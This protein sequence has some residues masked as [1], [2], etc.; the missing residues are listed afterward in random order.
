MSQSSG[1][2]TAPTGTYLITYG[3]G[4]VSAPT[5]IALTVDGSTPYPGSQLSVSGAVTDLVTNTIVAPIPVAPNNTFSMINLGGSVTLTPVSP[6]DVVAT[7][8]IVQLAP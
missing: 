8:N 6:G 2:F 4:G 3:I 7:M 1:V 5:T